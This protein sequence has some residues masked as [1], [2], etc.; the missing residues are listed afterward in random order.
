MTLVYETNT[1]PTTLS[2]PPTTRT[3][4]TQKNT[5]RLP[6]TLNIDNYLQQQQ[7]FETIPLGAPTAPK[8]MAGYCEE[9]QA[10]FDAA[11]KV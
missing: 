9:W 11:G 8:D 10:K 3:P 4:L 1:P 5:D 7:N 6:I 2:R